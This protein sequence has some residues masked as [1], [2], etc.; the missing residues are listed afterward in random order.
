ML[1]SPPP[2]PGGD[3]QKMIMFVEGCQYLSQILVKYANWCDS[4][5]IEPGDWGKREG[6]LLK[7]DVMKS[8][9]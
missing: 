3:V 7:Y 8:H 1:V 6:G 5:R 4:F 2:P 9:G